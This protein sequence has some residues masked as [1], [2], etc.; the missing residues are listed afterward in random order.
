[1][2]I[3]FYIFFVKK[4]IFILMEK[5]LTFADLHYQSQKKTTRRGNRPQCYITDV[6]FADLVFA[7]R[8]RVGRQHLRQ[9]VVQPFFR[10]P[11]KFKIRFKKL[12]TELQK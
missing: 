8:R 3:K 6:F 10:K 9:Q 5:I 2:L 1:M 12:K 11:R 4:Y 7:K